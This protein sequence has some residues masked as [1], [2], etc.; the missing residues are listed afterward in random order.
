MFLEMTSAS[1][2]S[3]MLRLVQ[4]LLTKYVDNEVERK[5]V[6]AVVQLVQNKMTYFLEQVRQRTAIYVCL[7]GIS[8]ILPICKTFFDLSDWVRLLWAII[9][10]G[11]VAYFLFK[12]IN[13]TRLVINFLENLEEMV[14]V[15]LRIEYEKAMSSSSVKKIAVGVL[16]SKSIDAYVPLVIFTAAKEFGLWLK[17]N[18]AACYWRL[19]SYAIVSWALSDSLSHLFGS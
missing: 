2:V 9:S 14:T 1:A 17:L 15:E 18:K 6:G 7:A 3:G 12:T 10:F 16:A 11:I 13:Q 5:V 19:G 4:E 8:L